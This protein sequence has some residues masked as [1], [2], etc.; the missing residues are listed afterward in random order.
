MAFM[1]RAT[2]K[3]QTQSRLFSAYWLYRYPSQW[4]AIASYG[5]ELAEGNES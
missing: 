3:S 1:P 5:A 4:V 2:S